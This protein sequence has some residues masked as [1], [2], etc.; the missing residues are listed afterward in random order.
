MLGILSTVEKLLLHVKGLVGFEV[1]V[2]QVEPWSGRRKDL[3]KAREEEGKGRVREGGW[4]DGGLPPARTRRGL[5]RG[6]AA[7]AVAAVATATTARAIRGTTAVAA[8]SATTAEAA[9]TTAAAALAHVTTTRSAAT[10]TT[11][12]AGSGR[13]EA[14]SVV[15]EV[16]EP[17]GNVLVG[18]LYESALHK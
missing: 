8:R 10:A 1:S 11:T 9:T 15:A 16:G 18:F 4:V 7:R 13:A 3:C 14:E 5:R 17:V 2:N 6:E 12:A